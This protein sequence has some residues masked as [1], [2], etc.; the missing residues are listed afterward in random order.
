MGEELYKLLLFNFLLTAAFAFLVSLPRRL[1]VERL[2][3]RFWAWLGRE[4][5]LVPKN[6]L[7]IVAGQTV[8]W[9]GL[10]YCPLLPLLNS[11][12]IFLTFYIKKYTLLRNSRAPRRLFRASS[13]TFFFQLVLL[14][15]LLL[16]AAPLGYVVSSVHSSWDCGLFTNYSAPWQVV[17][18][19]VALRLPPLGQRALGY[20]SSHAFGFPLLILLSIALTVCV[21][22]ARANARAIHTLRKQL[23]RQVQ[24][25]WH[26]VEDLS[27]LLPEPSPNEAPGPESPLSRASRPRS[28]RPGFPCPGS[29]GPSP[30]G[31]EPVHRFRFPSSRELWHRPSPPP[32]GPV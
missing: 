15:G 13:T 30:P 2:S 14:L 31:P 12:F 3:G 10:F 8:T 9:M 24:E 17:P 19:L 28:F 11:V 26:L 22:Q 18:E 32:Q 5:F 16:A 29:P 20:L 1:L 6:V 21:S 27:R 23:V 25:K 4:E 7:D